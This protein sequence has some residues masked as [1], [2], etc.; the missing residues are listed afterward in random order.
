MAIQVPQYNEPQVGLRSPSLPRARAPESL[1]A[2]GGGQSSAR[3]ANATQGLAET[4]QGIE[5]KERQ[6][7]RTN[8]INAQVIDFA[9]QMTM[10]E[11]ALQDKLQKVRGKDATEAFQGAM[12][13]YDKWHEKA[14]EEA[15]DPEVRQHISANYQRAR[16]SFYGRGMNYARQ[17]NDRYGKE[18]R[19][20][21]IDAQRQAAARNFDDN[22]SV[23]GSIDN[24]R[25]TY[26]E[27][28]R[29]EGHPQ[30]WVDK[31]AG[32][33][34]SGI[35]LSAIQSLHAD[36]R[37]RDAKTYLDTFKSDLNEDDRK[38][39]LKLVDDGSYLGEAQ[40]EEERIMSANPKS[41]SEAMDLA[42][43]IDDP[44]LKDM[45]SDRVKDRW[46]LQKASEKQAYAEH[47]DLVTN[48]VIKRGSAD[49]L[50]GGIKEADA[51]ELREIART[52]KFG[53]PKVSDPYILTHFEGLSV[54]EV[55]QY[56][57]ADMAMLLPKLNVGDHKAALNRRQSARDAMSG[58]G[59]AKTEWNSAFSRQEKIVE[60]LASYGAAGIQKGET[61][62]DFQ[63]KSKSMFSGSAK[64][65]AYI[66]F[67]QKINDWTLE[68][69]TLNGENPPEKEVEAEITREAFRR[70]KK[71]GI[72]KSFG[73]DPRTPISQLTDAQ[74]A[75]AYPLEVA[76]SEWNEQIEYIK[77]LQVHMGMEE[78]T[79]KK[80][81]KMLVAK[82]AG[83]M[84]LYEQFAR[85]K[86]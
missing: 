51:M 24:I 42:R 14:L 76:G 63:R 21:Y 81:Q 70:F 20:T 7:A 61:L 49:N 86:E 58:N 23:Q 2:F 54:D 36:K 55:A 35:R 18:V 52:V 10:Q 26:Q 44:K 60:A 43:K 31:L 69:H 57:D 65:D 37:D 53:Q 67:R 77:S 50:L 17:E 47:L 78:A 68:Y 83:R 64:L 48:E 27:M 19:L 5:V 79:A 4:V 16:E 32:D 59:K 12:N 13:D 56:T 66:D 62:K 30:G 40:R 80:V 74:F 28:A 71:V 6:E 11:N 46:T 72:H 25:S 3:L 9:G 73:T 22:A 8:A 84:D 29:I 75:N 38:T 34:K 41:L 85:E 33:E 1:E 45:V 39:A 82:R 15:Q